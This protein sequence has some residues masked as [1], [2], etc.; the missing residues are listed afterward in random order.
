MIRFVQDIK[1]FCLAIMI[2]GIVVFCIGL[3]YILIKAGIP[4]QDPTPEMQI[5]YSISMSVGKELTGIGSCMT[6]TGIVSRIIL[7]AIMKNK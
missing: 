1:Q 7:G 6:V 2:A 5:R 4:Y 3:F